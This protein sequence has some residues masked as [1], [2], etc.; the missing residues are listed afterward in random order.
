LDGVLD[1]PLYAVRRWILVLL[2]H[3]RVGFWLFV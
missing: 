3:A 2:L 1:G